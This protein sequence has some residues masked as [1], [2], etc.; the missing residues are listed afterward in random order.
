MRNKVIPPTHIH[1]TFNDLYNEDNDSISITSSISG[2]S[3][4]D[5]IEGNTLECASISSARVMGENNSPN[6]SLRIKKTRKVLGS[7]I[8]NSQ[9]T[10]CN[11]NSC[12]G[13]AGRHV[14]GK[15]S[16]GSLITAPLL[17]PPPPSYYKPPQ[18][19]T[20]S[21]PSTSD[22]PCHEDFTTRHC[23]DDKSVPMS[24][25]SF[26]KRAVALGY[27]NG[28]PECKKLVRLF[29][30][31]I[32][33]HWRVYAKKHKEVRRLGLFLRSCTMLRRLSKRF[34]HWLVRSS[35]LAHRK[36]TW[37]LPN[38][39]QLPLYKP[40]SSSPSTSSRTT[41]SS[42]SQQLCSSDSHSFSSSCASQHQRTHPHFASSTSIRG[43][44][45]LSSGYAPPTATRR[46]GGATDSILSLLNPRA[47]QRELPSFPS[48][49]SPTTITRVR[50]EQDEDAGEEFEQEREDSMDP[51]PLRTL[52]TAAA[53]TTSSGLGVTLS[54]SHNYLHPSLQGSSVGESV[55]VPIR[56]PTHDQIYEVGKYHLGYRNVQYSHVV[57]E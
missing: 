41:P 6:I 15:G 45:S 8:R 32:V 42:T 47:H 38:Q 44:N 10:N 40:S 29:L 31:E 57:S 20:A 1:G 30:E 19:Y 2:M 4:G 43:K 13:T 56:M 50:Y 3:D 21:T 16:R 27:S 34:Y 26:Q 52:V 54:S 33:T 39:K 17:M 18:Y 46:T 9:S 35:A 28:R 22:E 24:K 12:S 5:G 51:Y 49:T 48:I 25:T 55:S 37:I 11:S 23:D 7:D 36:S 53:T 14:G